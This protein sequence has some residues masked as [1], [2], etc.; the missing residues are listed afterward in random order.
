M[1]V[2]ILNTGSIPV[3]PGLLATIL[4][5]SVTTPSEP[6][7]NVG[8]W[9]SGT[10]LRMLPQAPPT[11]EALRV[12]IGARQLEAWAV[13]HRNGSFHDWH[14]HSGVQWMCTGVYYMTSGG[15]CTLFERDGKVIKSA[16]VAGTWIT[17]N[18]L[19]MHRTEPHLEAETRVTIAF[20]AR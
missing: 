20:N 19:L 10:R 11:L 6:G 17:F 1:T 15:G 13:V 3:D 8:G 9:R 2:G 7:H 14:V 18:S 12:A 16:P 4:H 5:E